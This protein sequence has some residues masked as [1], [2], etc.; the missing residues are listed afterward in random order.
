MFD[1]NIYL[2]FSALIINVS[3]GIK[4]LIGLSHIQNMV[5]IPQR[6]PSQPMRKLAVLTE[7]P[8]HALANGILGYFWWNNGE[9]FK[10]AYLI[11]NLE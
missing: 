6:I 9:I 5:K 10:Y 1:Y 4:T 11:M 2:L 3:C 7:Q 8:Q